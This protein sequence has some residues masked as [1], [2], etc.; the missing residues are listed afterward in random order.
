[1]FSLDMW[2]ASAI[3]ASPRYTTFVYGINGTV[4]KAVGCQDTSPNLNEV[5]QVSFSFFCNRPGITGVGP[6]AQQSSEW[7]K[8]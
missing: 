4:S 2:L 8:T 3:R 1:M 7:L 6:H 5:R